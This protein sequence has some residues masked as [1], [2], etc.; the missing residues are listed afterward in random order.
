MKK[1]IFTLLALLVCAV[2]S[3]WGAD[4]TYELSSFSKTEANGLATYTYEV[5][6][7]IAWKNTRVLV[8]VPSTANGTIDFKCGDSKTD[9]FQYIYK[10]NGTVKDETRK[11][12]MTKN[13]YSGSP[14][15]YTSDDILTSNGKYYLVFQTSDDFKATGIKYVTAAVK[16]TA[17]WDFK[18]TNPST[19]A[20]VNFWQNTGSVVSSDGETS[21]YVDASVTQGKLAYVT[22]GDNH[23]AQM[24]NGTKLQI[25]VQSV[26]DVVTIVAFPGQYKYTV[27]GVA[28]VADETVH[29]AT[30]KD[31]AQGYV[32]IVATATA[33]FYSI[34]LIQYKKSNQP[35]LLSFTAGETTYYADELTWAESPA[36]TFTTVINISTVPTSV[37]DLVAYVG[38]AT[39]S[40]YSTGVATITVSEGETT[41]TYIVIFGEA[42]TLVYDAN[43]GSGTMDNTE[44]AGSITLTPNAYTKDGYAFMGWATSQENAD[45]GIVAY[46][47]GADYMLSDNATLYAVWALVDYSFA[48]TASSG[49]LAANDVV[50]TSTGGKMVYNGQGTLKYST[51]S[52]NNC[53]EF[54]GGSGCAVTVTLDKVMKAG[55]VITLNYYTASATARGFFIANSEG[56]TKATFSQSVVGTYTESYTV[57]AGDGLADSNVF[58]IKRNNNA[59]LN[60]VMVINCEQ[61][62]SLTPAKTYTT[63]TSAYALDFTGSDIKAFIVEDDDATDGKITMTQVNKVPAGTGLVLKATTPNAAVSVPVFDGTGADNVADNKMEGSAI[64]TTAIAANAGYILKDGEFHPASAG[65]LAAGK[66]YLKIAVANAAPLAIDFNGETTGVKSIEHGT[67]NIEH[68]YDLQGR[69]VAQPTKGLYIV[70]GRK[71]VVK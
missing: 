33:Y 42:K 17:T 36:N 9:R 62:I 70:N 50:A 37:S 28:A 49:S 35:A 58:L 27:S 41:L 32:E 71:V 20:D 52:G 53:I 68:F 3:A 25:P 12:V 46:A 61:A 4:L 16:T 5:S 30:M 47:D 19:L 43:G 2:G 60:S 21:M 13:A 11:I 6:S 66:A 57:V 56:T 69:K 55:T 59:Y 44:G 67:L 64:E 51:T 22:N 7:S 48:P 45:A 24:N 63:L 26:N 34:D 65:T 31:V 10:T 38:T 18:N 29:K 14:I 54:G 1:N 15:S 39:L 8:E 40:S 23:Y